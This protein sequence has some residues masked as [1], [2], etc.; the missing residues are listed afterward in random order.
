[1]ARGPIRLKYAAT[2]A[3]CGAKLEAGAL[4][5]YYGKGRVYGVECHAQRTATPRVDST[6][7]EPLGAVYSRLDPYNAYSSDGE[8]IG[9]LC[10]CEDYPCCGH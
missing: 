3:D 5:R 8:R 7:D 6:A 2:C 10:G 9:A 4:A 1:M